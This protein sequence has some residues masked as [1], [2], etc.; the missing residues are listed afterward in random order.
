MKLLV[1]LVILCRWAHWNNNNYFSFLIAIYLYSTGA[2]VDA[3]TLL[4]YLGL[5]VSYNVLLK[6]LKTIMSSSN[7]FIK[8][9][10][11]NYKFVETWD[12]FKYG[13][14]VA[15]ERIDNIVKFKS[16]TMVLWIKNR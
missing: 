7:T 8:Q 13:K 10:P 6:R 11:T 12:N 1:I 9:Q 3:I 5:S 4:N 15:I 14:K 16:M 2:K